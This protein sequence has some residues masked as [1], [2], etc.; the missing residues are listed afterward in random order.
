MILIYFLF[1]ITSDVIV[2][3]FLI[4]WNKNVSQCHWQEEENYIVLRS[5]PK[6]V[7]GRCLNG[8]EGENSDKHRD[9]RPWPKIQ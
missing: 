4:L 2:F 3:L 9:E 8:V 5:E 1:T 6:R 7:L